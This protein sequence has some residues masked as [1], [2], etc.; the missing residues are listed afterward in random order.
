MPRILA[1]LAFILAI[2]G[3]APTALAEADVRVAIHVDESDPTKMNIVLNNAQNI[4]SY[5]AEQG[6]TVEIAIVAHGPGLTMLRPDK[7]PVKERLE[8]MELSN[9]NIR[10]EACGNTLAA[11]TQ[12]EG[13]V[14]PPLFGNVTVVP[15]GA[16]RLIELQQQGWA[17]L[18]P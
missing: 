5:Y 12:K 10:L 9:P 14:T 15:S 8:V 3:A 1:A 17:Y 2:A 4:E 11:M 6:K 18:K 7:S 13:G 16:V